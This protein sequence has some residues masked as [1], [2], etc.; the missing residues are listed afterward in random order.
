MCLKTNFFSSSFRYNDSGTLYR[1]P[2]CKRKWPG[3]NSEFQT[4]LGYTRITCQEKILKTEYAKSTLKYVFCIQYT[5]SITFL[6]FGDL[7]N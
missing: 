5:A 3:L 2:V 1:V 4:S 6:T 7:L